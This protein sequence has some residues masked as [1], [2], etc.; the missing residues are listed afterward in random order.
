MSANRRTVILRLPVKAPGTGKTYRTTSPV[1]GTIRR[2]SVVTNVSPG[3]LDPGP[4]EILGA[5][6]HSEFR[7]TDEI[8]LGTGVSSWGNLTAQGDLVQA[9]GSKQPA[10][11]A[12]AFNGGPA[13]VGDGSN[14]ELIATVT[15]LLSGTRPYAWVVLQRVAQVNAGDY[16][17]SMLDAIPNGPNYLAA[18][19]DATNWLTDRG[20]ADG[21]EVTSHPATP[22]TGR[23]L[24]ELGATVGGTA[25]FA[26]DGVA[27][28]G[29]KSGALGANIT[30]LVA[31]GV[32]AAGYC[33]A[34]RIAHIVVA[35]DA[36]SAGQIAD[37]R[38]YFRGP[39]FPDYTGGSYGL[40][41]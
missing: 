11:S 2:F 14:D 16:S 33:A 17:F 31:C 21:T 3:S 5:L 19:T 29:A 23:H 27:I 36:P 35:S 13:V 7:A 28:N 37:M 38:T 9:T 41:S 4:E 10:Y 8:T 30:R 24:I 40:P 12:T 26:I 34:V 20:L 22:D 32:A 1:A 39:N 15:G 18:H 25:C 6:W